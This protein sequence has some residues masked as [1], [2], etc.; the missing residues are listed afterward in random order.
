MWAEKEMLVKEEE[1]MEIWLCWLKKRHISNLHRD[2]LNVA[3]DLHISFPDAVF[4]I[5]VEVPPLMDGQKLKYL[6]AH[7]VV[8]YS[9]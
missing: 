9:G 3:Y 7:R 4:G 6:Q 8:K 1:A 2:G 5:Q